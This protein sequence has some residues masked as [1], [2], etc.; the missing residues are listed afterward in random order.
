MSLPH[1]LVVK[2]ALY[3]KNYKEY[4]QFKNNTSK[5][6]YQVLLSEEQYQGQLRHHVIL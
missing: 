6:I 5:Y 1:E 4:L 2:T 3:I